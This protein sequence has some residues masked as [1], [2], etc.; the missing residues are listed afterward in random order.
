M[1]TGIS[2]FLLLGI[3]FLLGFMYLCNNAPVVD[4]DYGNDSYEEECSNGD[5]V[6]VTKVDKKNLEGVTLKYKNGET[7][8]IKTNNMI[9]AYLDIM[10]DEEFKMN[11]EVLC[12]GEE[13]YILASRLLSLCVALVDTDN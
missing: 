7:V 1:L 9:L 11:V 5:K 3:A 10:N 6:K 2:V 13:R 12:R 4:D 8:E